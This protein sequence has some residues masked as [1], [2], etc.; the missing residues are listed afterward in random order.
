MS[1]DVR[2]DDPVLGQVTWHSCQHLRRNLSRVQHEV[3][4][5]AQ[6]GLRNHS[7]PVAVLVPAER[8][9]HHLHVQAALEEALAVEG[10]DASRLDH[11]R[12]FL[13][14]EDPP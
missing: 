13:G 14:L 11:V 10:L 1:R 5:G 9:A 4:D 6:V 7:R 8:Y 12:S 3:L 2:L